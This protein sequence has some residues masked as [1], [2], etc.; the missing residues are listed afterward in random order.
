MYNKEGAKKGTIA[1]PR[2]ILIFL[3]DTEVFCVRCNAFDALINFKHTLKDASSLKSY[4]L[5]VNSIWL[6]IDF[7]WFMH[8][9]SFN[10]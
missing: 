6:Q 9:I 1:L 10:C 4:V 5:F 2:M 7:N 8:F 3:N